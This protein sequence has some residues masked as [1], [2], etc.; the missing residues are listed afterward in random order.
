MM[1]CSVCGSDLKH[2][3]VPCVFC[4]GE[5]C[6]LCRDNN[7]MLNVVSCTNKECS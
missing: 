1:N 2:E 3:K 4:D 6:E 7:G 5:G